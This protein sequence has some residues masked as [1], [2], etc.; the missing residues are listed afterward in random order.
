MGKAHKLRQTHTI[1][2]AVF[3]LNVE[4]NTRTSLE[5]EMKVRMH[6]STLSKAP[7]GA[8]VVMSGAEG[9]V[10]GGD[11]VACDRR[12]KQRKIHIG[13]SERNTVL[14]GKPLILSHFK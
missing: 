9:R 2:D 10:K 11:V 14:Y 13:H 1:Y 4:P 7:N 6:V 5:K 8:S 12:K 3:E